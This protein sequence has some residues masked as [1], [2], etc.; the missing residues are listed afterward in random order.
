MAANNLNEHDNAFFIYFFFAKISDF[1]GDLL[2]RA[3]QNL[4]I[5]LVE[6][7]HDIILY[8]ITFIYV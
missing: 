6:I 4:G 7:G 1:K 5:C 3:L 8:K 2:S